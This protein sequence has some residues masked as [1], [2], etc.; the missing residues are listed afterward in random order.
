MDRE[1]LLQFRITGKIGTGGMGEV[2]KA[3]DTRLGRGVALKVLPPETESDAHSRARLLHEARAAS[4]LNHPNIITIYEVGSDQGV[5]FIAMEYVDGETL[6][7]RLQKGPLPARQVVEYGLQICDALEAAHSLGIVHR[8]LKPKNIMITPSARIKVL[9]FGLAKQDRTEPGPNDETSSMSTEAGALAGSPAYM[10][11][12]Q[13]AGDHVDARSDLFSLGIVMHEMLSGKLPFRGAT[14]LECL[15]SRL[16]ERPTALAGPGMPPQLAEV[17]SKCLAREP[18][19]RYQTAGDLAADLRRV[20]ATPSRARMPSRRVALVAGVA[21]VLVGAAAE[22]R[23]TTSTSSLGAKD[24]AAHASYEQARS[25]LKRYDQPG[26]IDRAIE[27]LNHAIHVSAKYAPAYTGL[28]DA[29]LLRNITAKDSQ[30]VKLA[31]E[32]GQRAIAL[33]PNLAAARVALGA[34]YLESGR[35]DEGAAELQRGLDLDPLSVAANIAMAKLK[36]RGGD[37]SEAERLLHQAVK[38]GA[39]DWIPH[40]ELGIFYYRT[41][42][43]PEASAA[44][45]QARSRSPDNVRVLR[46][47]IAVYTMLDRYADAAAAAQQALEIEPT[48]SLYTNVGTMLFYQGRYLDA[49]PAFQKA[50][51]LG[52]NNYLYWG[53]LGD[54]YRWT[55]GYPAESQEA[56][57]HAIQLVRERLR[58]APSDP[59]LRSSLAVY[60]AKSGH[61]T[62][63]LAELAQLEGLPNRNAGSRFKSALAYEIAGQRECALNALRAAIAAGQP[64]WEIRAEPDLASLRADVR[65]HRMLPVAS[66]VAQAK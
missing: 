19:A 1:C 37:I 20:S 5:D 41:G 23:R 54:G 51:E 16:Y 32:Y 39:G 65:Y 7:D 4:A 2:W 13:A 48:A 44:F 43:Y 56:F 31:V 35:R 42:R 45:E 55:P 11:P 33:N 21:L 12:E 59:E 25:I 26:N 17:V 64:L 36:Y 38:L 53:N 62:E 15:R 28:A 10:S 52:A 3:V 40:A 9:D 6:R 61:K 30:W 14:N 22:W 49:L 47:L 46:N 57:Q 58:T 27:A 8:D 63:A 34:A 18:E 60:L 24:R 29:Y 66:L 50:V